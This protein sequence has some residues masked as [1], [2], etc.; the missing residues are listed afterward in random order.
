MRLSTSLSLPSLSY[1]QARANRFTNLLLISITWEAV[2]KTALAQVRFIAILISMVS[3]EAQ[4][5]FFLKS[6]QGML[7]CNRELKQNN[8]HRKNTTMKHW[9]IEKGNTVLP[10]PAEGAPG[11][12]S[13]CAEFMFYIL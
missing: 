2:S 6:P 4:H 1:Q 13:Q 12:Q 11:K 3:D 5:W 8:I 10:A 7:M 9:P